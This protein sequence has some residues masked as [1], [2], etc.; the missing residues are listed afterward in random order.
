VQVCVHVGGCGR[1]CQSA[2][3]A[4][5]THERGVRWP[6]KRA[7]VHTHESLHRCECTWNILLFCCASMY[8]K[9]LFSAGSF[10]ITAACA[11]DVPIRGHVATWAS[12]CW[13]TNR[14]TDRQSLQAVSVVRMQQ[15]ARSKHTNNIELTQQHLRRT[16]GG[17]SSATGSA[18][19]KRPWLA[20]V[21]EQTRRSA[22]GLPFTSSTSSL[23]LHSVG[24]V[25][26]PSC[27]EF[28]W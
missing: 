24:E 15:C 7:R 12:V 2:T 26:G 27:G 25:A 18:P 8:H 13:P 22:G 19:S 21:S 3:L 6:P 23:W 4:R 5:C 11:N 17:S 16:T 9:R 1:L 20:R 14:P 10:L 28:L